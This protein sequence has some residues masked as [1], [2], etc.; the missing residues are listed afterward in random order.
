MW[1][2]K[3]EPIFLGACASVD[4][5]PDSRS[6]CLGLNSHFRNVKKCWANLV[7]TSQN[8]VPGGTKNRSPVIM[9][10]GCLGVEIGHFR[11]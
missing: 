6:I 5:V 2:L 11:S 10:V 7:N 9:L 4:Q 1:M 8:W 3:N